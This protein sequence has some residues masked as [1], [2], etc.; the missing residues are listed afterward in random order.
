[1]KTI[2]VSINNSL[3]F[4]TDKS[5]FISFN[6]DA[7]IVN[8]IR[9]L[10]RKKW[11]AD[12]K[13]WEV[14][15]TDEDKNLLSY[16][17][18]QFNK[19]E[20]DIPQVAEKIDNKE[21]ENIEVSD[22][23]IY[24]NIPL[25]Q[26]QID[27]LKFGIL[28]NSFLLADEMGLGKTLSIINYSIWRKYN[29]NYK[30]A[31]IVAGVNGLKYNWKNEIERYTSETA[32]ILGMKKNKCKSS[33]EIIEDLKDIDNNKNYFLI[34]NIES[35][36]NKDIAKLIREL[37][38]DNKIELIA[39]DEAQCLKNANSQQA[40]NFRT[41]KP[42][43]K[44]AATGTPIMNKPIELYT[45]FNWLGIDTHTYFQFKDYYC[46]MGGYKNYEIVGYKHLDDLQ[47]KL[48]IMML[49]RLRKDILDL[50]D[51][52]YTEEFVELSVAQKKLYNEVRNSIVEKLKDI[53]S[54]PNALSLMIRLR[55][56]TADTSIISDTVNESA[57]L[58]RLLELVEELKD[59]GKKFIIYSNWETVI[60]KVKEK[61]NNFNLSIVTGKVKE[62]DREKEILMF[63]NGETDGIIGTV[64]ALGTG[65]TL[66]EAT[67]VIFL[68]SPWTAATKEQAID[69][70]YRIGQNSKVNVITI[71]AKDTIDERIEQVVYSKKLIA[72]SIVDKTVDFN[73]PKE[74]A[75]YL[76][77]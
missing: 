16:I 44:I 17:V 13:V 12:K 60:Q 32:H 56:T 37:T 21:L 3:Y 14:P 42:K 38:I 64:G 18:K 75:E 50:P 15:Y 28:K 74:L 54:I 35:I 43:T 76:L 31:L 22:K 19:D 26:H 52:T 24:T 55:Q 8:E 33:K 51:K 72:D 67:T 7:K 25:M 68:D 45:I 62:Q 40:K 20:S 61:L 53:D 70:A 2:N 59:N 41:L 6:Y 5:F 23:D 1:M 29:S 34:T 27:L 57:K 66:T 48:D 10:P 65:Y 63:K 4:K 71:I 36:R 69:R 77:S 47:N 39:I 73:N 30:H 11:W 46:V 49:R 9:T 58:D